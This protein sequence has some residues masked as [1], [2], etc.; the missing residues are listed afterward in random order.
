MRGAQVLWGRSYESGGAPPYWP[1]VQAIRSHVASTEPDT[2]RNQMG[3]TAPIIAE[4]VS[5]VR[6]KLPDLAALTPID[7]PESARFRLFDAIATFLKQASS[8]TDWCGS[9]PS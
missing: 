1:W 5:D 6:E 9:I 8:S 2:L 7:D 3:S 4:V